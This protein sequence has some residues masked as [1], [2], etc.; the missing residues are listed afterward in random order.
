[1]MGKMP[2][3]TFYHKIRIFSVLA[4]S[5]EG[6]DVLSTLRPLTFINYSNQA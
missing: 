1:M 5:L 3:F 2:Q 4:L 6:K